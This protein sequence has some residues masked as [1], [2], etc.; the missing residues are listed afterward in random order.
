MSAETLH[1]F[2]FS[3]HLDE[4]LMNVEHCVM[5]KFIGYDLS[6]QA[7]PVPLPLCPP[8]IAHRLSQIEPEP[9]CEN[10]VTNSLGY[11]TTPTQ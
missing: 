9:P 7:N 10:W 1:G 3:Q 6:T 4:N 2:P 11:G 8:L 5:W